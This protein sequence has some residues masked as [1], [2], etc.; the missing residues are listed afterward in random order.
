MYAKSGHNL[1]LENIRRASALFNMLKGTDPILCTSDYRAATFAK[2]E[3]GVTKGVGIDVIGNLPHVMERGDM[4]IYD[5]S[6]EASETMQSHMNEFC[7]HIYKVGKDIP[8]DVVDYAF[9][10]KKATKRKKVL[11]FSDDDYANWFFNLSEK[12]K[13]HDIPLL[14]G[15]YFFFKNEDKL[16]QQYIEVIEEEEYVDTIQTTAYLLTSSIHSCLESIAS[17]N[18][19][20]YFKRLDKENIENYELLKKYNIPV[21]EKNDIENL[22]SVIT[23]FESVIKNYPKINQIEKYDISKIKNEIENT[24]KLFESV[25]P[26]LEYKF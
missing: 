12:S 24:L 16:A 19:P 23:E 5:D 22:D 13:K 10:G 21:I 11:F 4:L 20:V 8:K 2:A 17:G 7:K 3:L 9:F 26:S 15:H 14:W 25:K 18:S 1:G 6:D